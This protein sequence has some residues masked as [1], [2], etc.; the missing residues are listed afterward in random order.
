MN[1]TIKKQDGK[2]VVILKGSLDTA[3]AAET[4]EAMSPLYDVT[5]KD[6]ILDCTDLEYISSAGMRIFLDILQTT[7][8]NGGDVYIKGIRDEVR[9]IFVLTGFEKLYKFI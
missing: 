4:E 9:H 8:K 5:G 2:I 6:I 1:T 3:F 7:N